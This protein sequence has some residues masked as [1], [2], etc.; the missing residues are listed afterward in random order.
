MNLNQPLDEDALKNATRG[1]IHGRLFEALVT[2][3]ASMALMFLGEVP[4]PETG[5]K[6]F[7]PESAKLYIDQL[8]M[9]Q[10]KTRGNLAPAEEKLLLDSLKL[11]RRALVH[12]LDSR[13]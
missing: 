1:E 6:V 8:E 3:Q 7:E 4:H 13:S 5:D 9:L 12:V 2:Q 10:A 11:V